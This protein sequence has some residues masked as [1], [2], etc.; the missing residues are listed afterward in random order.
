MK[1]NPDFHFSFFND[2]CA[3][4]KLPESLNYSL[5]YNGLIPTGTT[6]IHFCGLV[7]YEGKTAIFLPRNS[8]VKDNASK[9][10]IAR[11]LLRSI[12]RYKQAADS[13]TETA[14][15]GNGIIGSDSLS[16][17]ISL[18][19]DYAVN[20]LY[21]R[22]VRLTFRNN[23]KTDWSK[24]ISRMPS[25]VV[26][27]D[28]FYPEIYGTKKQVI[29]DCDISRIHAQII[30]SLCLS[31]GWITFPN[32]GAIIQKLSHIPP[33]SISKEVQISL[34]VQELHTAYS[35]RDIFLL[36]NLI[37]YLKKENGDINNNM[38]IGI[39]E[40]HGLWERMLDTCLLHTEKVNHRLT[41]PVYKVS[42]D[43]ILASSKGHRTDTV[44]R[45]PDE[46]KY[47]IIDAKYYE[48][49]NVATAPKLSD[50]VKQFYYAKAMLLIEKEAKS[51]INVFVF[52]G[53]KG[54]IESVHMATKG[55]KGKY[56]KE[57]CLDSD[58]PPILCIYQ[59]PIEL[60]SHYSQGIPLR[61]LSQKIINLSLTDSQPS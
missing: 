17:F 23:G 28:I 53:I 10:E 33:P 41:A 31:I 40:C 39:R 2:R 38:V 49:R 44:L 52:P 48:A 45:H 11:S 47:V 27:D 42:G 29:H 56:R 19:N 50:I 35:D 37:Q 7:F 13:A 18:I 21:S 36:K 8:E 58:Y 32:P 24:T 5:R 22:R 12:H 25:F 9:E 59:D 43:Y 16:L 1:N 51:V 54:N 3:V 20:G 4:S 26:G 30:R 6:N 60:L 34:L 57:D 15:E 14:D 55:L 46:N 61:E